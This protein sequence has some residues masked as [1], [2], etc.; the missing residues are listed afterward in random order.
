MS[1]STL[2]GR[3]LRRPTSVAREKDACRRLGQSD[4]PDR[5][6]MHM[7]DS[8]TSAAMSARPPVRGGAKHCTSLA[9]RQ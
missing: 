9:L 6:E 3:L 2:S 7:H 5:R 4:E 1:S 8:Q